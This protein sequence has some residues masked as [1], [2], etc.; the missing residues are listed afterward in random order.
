MARL[1]LGIGHRVRQPGNP[2]PLPSLP[3]PRPAGS[4]A[5]RAPDS[6][7]RE[8][9]HELADTSRVDRRSHPLGGGFGGSLEAHESA[10]ERVETGVRGVALGADKQRVEAMLWVLDA[11]RHDDAEAPARRTDS[12]EQRRRRLA[13]IPKILESRPNEV[14]AGQVVPVM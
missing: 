9:L 2:S 13:A 12:D 6:G 3:P 11:L 4:S 7:A 10:H 8:R 5:D 1:K 14:A